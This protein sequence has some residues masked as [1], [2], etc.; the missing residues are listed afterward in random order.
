MEEKPIRLFL[1]TGFL[2]SGKT[3]FLINMLNQIKDTRVGVI[4]N[5]FGRIGIDGKVMQKG[6][7]KLVEINDGSIFCSCLKGGFVRTLVAFLEQ[8]IDLL[9]VEAS[10][11]ADPANM[12]QLVAELTPILKKRGE[13]KRRYDYRG[14]VCILDAKRFTMYYDLFPAIESQI[15]QSDFIVLNKMDEIDSETA[16]EHIKWLKELH[17]G[18]DIFPAKYGNVPVQ[19]FID[20]IE[21]HPGS[22][23]SSNTPE[24]RPY[25]CVIDMKDTYKLEDIRSLCSTL[26]D[27]TLRIKGFFRT[28]GGYG[29]ADCVSDYI[30]V[31]AVDT[32]ANGAPDTLKLVVIS[33]EE[34]GIEEMITESLKKAAL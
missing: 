33:K 24:N 17:P 3:S 14:S 10:G 7:L 34:G 4:V 31:E 11:M 16:D 22:A 13:I 21:A 5:E 27:S 8:P 32:A 28:E 25:S 6:D 15:V 12:Q 19:C 20:T 1:V 30:S 23:P 18:I 26:A 29:R 9:F 2:G